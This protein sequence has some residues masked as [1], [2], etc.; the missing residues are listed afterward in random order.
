MVFLALYERLPRLGVSLLCYRYHLSGKC[1]EIVEGL[2]HNDE[3]RKKSK[4]RSRKDLEKREIVNGR[5]REEAQ[6]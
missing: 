3:M 4:E 6:K 5:K 2:S 1:H